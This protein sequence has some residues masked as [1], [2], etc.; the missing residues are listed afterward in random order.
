MCGSTE[1]AFKH[2]HKTKKSLVHTQ[3][4]TIR[5]Q[6]LVLW[7]A[8]AHLHVCAASPHIECDDRGYTKYVTMTE[9]TPSTLL[10]CRTM[11]SVSRSHRCDGTDPST[12]TTH[13]AL[14]FFLETGFSPLPAA[15]QRTLPPGSNAAVPM[16]TGRM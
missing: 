16:E 5:W 3:W 1:H 2:I 9:V 15:S 7:D 8:R 11:C 13:Q 14:L 12:P 4:R 10:Q 6:T